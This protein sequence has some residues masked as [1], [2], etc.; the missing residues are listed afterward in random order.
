MF[1]SEEEF[2]ENEYL[3]VESNNYSNNEIQLPSY[4]AA[5]KSEY[6]ASIPYIQYK[7]SRSEDFD[8][9]GDVPY[10]EYFNL[11]DLLT[12]W[13]ATDTS[14]SRWNHSSAHYNRNN[15]GLR[16][17]NF[18]DSNERHLAQLYRE[19][20]VPFVLFDVPA[21][22]TAAEKYFSI[23]A[24]LRLFGSTRRPAEK[25][26][27]KDRFMYYSAKRK[28]ETV[29]KLFPSWV[30]PQEDVLITFP[31][32]LLE[33]N[34][35]EKKKSQSFAASQ[36]LIYMTIAAGEGLRTPWIRE[37][38]PFFDESD[39]FFIVDSTEFLGINC[40]FG[41]NGIIAAAHY[42]G[43]R[44]F[45]AMIRGRKRYVLLPPSECSRLDLYPRGHPS[46]RHAMVDWADISQLRENSKLYHAKATEVNKCV[47]SFQWTDISNFFA[48]AL[49]LKV[50]LSM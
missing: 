39:S 8:L 48:F 11:G 22:D 28:V 1:R 24:L 43:K 25:S 15:K 30:P 44:N 42:D 18:S 41:M 7:Y 6:S 35:A 32:F 3:L 12:Q 27:N 40:R 36:E 34:D 23:D 4:R 33:A 45:I 21:L 17:F 20:E 2:K 13:P 46:A 5:T 31:E 14:P 16:R 19:R 29:M 50:V 37:A 38:L 49:F 9:L 26:K 10:P 47:Y